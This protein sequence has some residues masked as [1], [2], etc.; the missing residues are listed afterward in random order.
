M[1]NLLLCTVIG[2]FFL[3]PLFSQISGNVIDDT[4]IPVSYANVVLNRISDSTMVKVEMTD[5]VGKFV[6]QGIP[7]GKYQVEISYVGLENY[8]SE[9]FDLGD[10]VIELGEIKMKK[11]TGELS[12]VTVVASRPVL[13]VEPDKL[14]FNVEG[15]VNSSGNS[16][17]EL[18]RKAP[19]VVVDNNE[20]VSLAGKN[21]I[22]I[23]INGKPSYL[24]GED[25]AAYLRNIRSEDIDKIEIIT[26]PSSKFEAEG[27]AGIINIIMK[28]DKKLGANGRL[29]LGYGQGRRSSFNGNLSGNYKNKKLNAFGRFSGG[30]YKGIN[31]FDL[32]RIQQGTIYD[33]V[34]HRDFRSDYQNFNVGLDLFLNEKNT[35]GI[36]IDGGHNKRHST[37][38]GKTYISD[39]DLP[40]L[41]EMVLVSGTDEDFETNRVNANLN[42]QSILKNNQNINLDLDYGIY[43][44]GGINDQPNYYKDANEEIILSEN[45]LENHSDT[46]ISIATFKMDYDRKLWGG[47]LGLGVKTSWVNTD[48]LFEVY[49]VV[50]LSSVF[51]EERSRRFRY[52]ENINAVY[53]SYGKNWGKLGMQ[54]GLRLEQTYSNGE[55]ESNTT[56]GNDKVKRKYVDIFPS[57]GFSYSVNE[58][59]QLRLNYSRRLQR[60][61]YENLNPFEDMLDELVFERGNP[62]LNP[63]YSNTVTLSHT[64]N[65]R[66]N[67]S[68]SYSHTKDKMA[69]IIVSEE[70]K[71][72]NSWLNVAEQNSIN[73]TF[74]MPVPV[75]KW[76][77]AYTNLTGSYNRNSTYIPELDESE[78]LEIYSFNGYLQNNFNLPKGFRMELSGWYTSP[79]VYGGFVKMK[80]MYAVNFGVQKSFMEGKAKLKLAFDDIF[81]STKWKGENTYGRDFA[82]AEGL[83]DSRRVKLNFSYNFGN[84]NVKS[85]K[86]KSGSMEESDRLGE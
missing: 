18:L 82:R 7:K 30:Q 86:R 40:E 79:S 66:M 17:L 46:D 64:F 78:L 20:N 5:D 29:G 70:N 50:D 49:N 10:S 35:L 3:C 56:S 37:A 24:T 12:E 53:T 54:V 72:F 13:Q 36:L 27:N 2:V 65:H 33:Q 42:F 8:F 61:D 60:P 21:G 69:E 62:F 9:A 4:G 75:T 52:L 15:S 76:W 67:T 81:Y 57:L 83:N 43:K 23:F 11:S 51:N 44:S 14:I 16:A 85:R 41:I 84:Q 22:Q 77:D 19:G 80:Q 39:V 1:K 73:L 34:S 58:K 63:E 45:I 25:L 74:G 55:L 26:N 71:I 6:F 47:E 28:K 68:I 31:E 38:T 59:N 48:N 32:Y